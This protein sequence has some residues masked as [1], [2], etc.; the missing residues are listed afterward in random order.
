[1]VSGMVAVVGESEPRVPRLCCCCCCT[2][3]AAAALLLHCC[4][5]GLVLAVSGLAALPSPLHKCVHVS[6]GTNTRMNVPFICALTHSLTHST[7]SSSFKRV[8]HVTTTTTT[9][10][11]ATTT[12]TTT[13]N[14]PPPLPAH[15]H[16]H[17]HTAG[18]PV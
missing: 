9:T 6:I 17:T 13:S 12:T 7:H 1:V 15:T 10:T 16:P 5:F 8:T 4:Y 18:P 11:T 3:A 2:A 14:A